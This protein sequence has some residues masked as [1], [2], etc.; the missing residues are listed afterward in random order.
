M[1]NEPVE[2]GD[3]TLTD[4]GD[5]LRVTLA[6]QQSWATLSVAGASLAVDWLLAWLAEQDTAHLDRR[7]PPEEED[8]HGA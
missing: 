7:S 3:I 1:P 5:R 8:R 2:I 6:E 4:L